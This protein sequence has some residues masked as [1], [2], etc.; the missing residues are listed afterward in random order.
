MVPQHIKLGR[1]SDTGEQLLPNRTDDYGTTFLD[2][3]GEFAGGAI[4][5]GS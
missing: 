2:E 4:N 3:V 5:L 1:I